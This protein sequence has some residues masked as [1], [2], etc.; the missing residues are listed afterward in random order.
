MK[1]NLLTSVLVIPYRPPIL[2][3]K[4]IASLDVM[5]GG[6]L[7]LGV[8]AGWMREEFEAVGA[9]DFNG[10][11]KVTDEYIEAFRILCTEH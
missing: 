2:A 5:S 6:R 1:I 10:R 8:G 9:P 11:G 7:I 4:M 3:A